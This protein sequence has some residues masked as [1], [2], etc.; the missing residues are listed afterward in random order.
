MFKIMRDWHV[1]IISC[2]RKKNLNA[3]GPKILKNWR[4]FHLLVHNCNS[5][6]YQ[7]HINVEW[8]NRSTLIKYLFKYINKGYDR[9]TTAIVANHIDPSTT[10]SVE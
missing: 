5:I 9:I 8:C 3:S 1:S 7:V 6:R 2:C 4:T 10:E